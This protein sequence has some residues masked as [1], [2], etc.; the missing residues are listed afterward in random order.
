MQQLHLQKL[1]LI[2]QYTIGETLETLEFWK[3]D[4]QIETEGIAVDKLELTSFKIS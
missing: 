3:L 1:E 2:L 4:L